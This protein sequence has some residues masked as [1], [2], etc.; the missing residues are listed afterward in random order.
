MKKEMEFNDE[1]DLIMRIEVESMEEEFWK[2]EDIRKINELCLQLPDIYQSIINKYY[3]K[4]MCYSD[5]ALEEGISIKTV[6]SRLYRARKLLKE[7]W[8]EDA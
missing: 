2:K 5:I 4:D 1:V 8:K 6:E 3:I 7:R